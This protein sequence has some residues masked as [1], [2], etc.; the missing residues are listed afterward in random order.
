MYYFISAFQQPDGRREYSSQ[1][2]ARSRRRQR[3]VIFWA[4]RRAKLGIGVGGDQVVDVEGL[5]RSHICGWR[6]AATHHLYQ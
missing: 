4:I 3:R 2:A 5:K 1:Y 6:L